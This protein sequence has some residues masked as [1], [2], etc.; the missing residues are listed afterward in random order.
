M[1]LNG[2]SSWEGRKMNDNVE[3]VKQNDF[4]G[5][6]V[7]VYRFKKHSDYRNNILNYLSSPEIAPTYYNAGSHLRTDGMSKPFII[8]NH[9]CL[10]D[11]RNAMQTATEHFYKDVLKA[12]FS[13]DGL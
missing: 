6:P 5:F 12:D 2:E 10:S 11:L 8:N 13:L 4:F 7:C 3:L 1:Q 9:E